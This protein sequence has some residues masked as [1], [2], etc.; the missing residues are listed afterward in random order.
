MS[1]GICPLSIV[2]V[3]SSAAEKSEM[4]S[5]LLFGEMVE[6]LE[7]KGGWLKIR[8]LWDNYL[9]WVDKL[10]I[11]PINSSQKDQY[12][13]NCACSLEIVHGAM[14]D[15]FFLPITM[16]ASIPDFDG[17]NFSFND[18]SF[19][20]SGQVVFPQ[21]IEVNSDFLLKVARRYLNAPYL[22][23]GRSPMGIDCSG[24]TQ[25]VFKLIGLKLPRD[26]YQQVEKGRLID[27]ID[28]YQPG[29]LAFFENKK[30][31]ISHVGILMPE[32]Q[33]IHASGKVR[34]DRIDH[35]GIFNEDLQKYTHKLRVVKR[36]LPEESM[37]RPDE[38][39]SDDEIQNQV[40]LFS[41]G[42]RG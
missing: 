30:G 8:C 4:V 15:D 14:A 12:S 42:Q 9:G 35:F 21:S 7:E 17:I 11:L 24:L 16:G 18:K 26:A 32:G 20:F 41:S 13:N 22:W 1:F 33:I 19:T 31:N 27:F 40:E 23:G 6:I 29:D 36:L 3:R 37:Q 38:E 39:S 5:Q 2:P 10:Q 28:Q 25:M 34:I